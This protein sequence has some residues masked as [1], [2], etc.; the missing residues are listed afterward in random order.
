MVLIDTSC[1]VEFFKKGSEPVQNLLLTDTVIM[2]DF[3]IGE[4]SLGQFSPNYRNKIFD[5]L[6]SLEKVNSGSHDQVLKFCYDHHLFGKGIGWVDAH[7]LYTT[8]H[9]N[10][11]IL[12]FDKKLMIL[13][14]QIL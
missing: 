2:H 14:N 5:L 6:L 9:S 8:Y 10:A 13:A 1:W 12:S 4:L 7:L 11:K 3:V